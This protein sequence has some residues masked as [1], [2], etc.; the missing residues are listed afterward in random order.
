MPSVP[1]GS[2]F[3]LATAFGSAKV[4][5]IVSNAAEAVFTSA[6]HG[7]TV[8]MIVEV[9]SGWG[10]LHK[11]VYRIKAADTN[12]FT[13]ELCN[14]TNT[15]LFPAGVGIGSVRQIITFVQVTKVMNPTSS[16]GDPKKVA[17]KYV[18]SDI[19][20][21]LNDGFTATDYAFEV[22]ADSIGEAGYTAMQSLTEVQTDTCLKI[23]LK[24]GSLL[25]LPGTI[26]LNE[27]VQMQEGQ[28]NRNK[29]AF[30]GNNRLTRYAS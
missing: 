18:E 24:N 30:S 25:F 23:V 28:I 1:T 2:T 5:T 9:T 8:G 17:Y 22:D 3:N 14:T 7:L 13:L 16:G 4:T 29:V 20:Y 15:N 10:R 21:S 12:T 11:R 19:E 6:A 27:S 26:A